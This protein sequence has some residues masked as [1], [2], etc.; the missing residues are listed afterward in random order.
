MSDKRILQVVTV[1]LHPELVERLD[2]MASLTTESRSTVIRQALI[3]YLTR[4]RKAS[5]NE[6]Q[7][8]QE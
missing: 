2:D 3:D 8:W 4:S 1:K 7:R 6:A 5:N